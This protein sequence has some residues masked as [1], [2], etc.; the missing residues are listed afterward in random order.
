MG[1]A[2]LNLWIGFISCGVAGL[3]IPCHCDWGGVKWCYSH[4]VWAWAILDLTIQNR[5][6]RAD[7][8]NWTCLTSLSNILHLE[9]Q[10]RNTCIYDVNMR[11][12]YTHLFFGM[13][14]SEDRSEAIYREKTP[15]NRRNRLD[16]H[17]F[18]NTH[19]AWVKQPFRST[20]TLYFSWIWS[21]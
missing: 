20:W 18:L 3:A 19:Q 17:L 9:N 15:K 11:P 2:C 21:I 10:R 5:L 16:S 13:V 7:V 1:W 12:W 4:E 14:T 6:D 8:I